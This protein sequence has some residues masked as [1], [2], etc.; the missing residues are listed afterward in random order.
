M[1]QIIFLNIMAFF[2]LILINLNEKRAFFIA[3]ALY[4]IIS[5]IFLNFIN[6]FHLIKIID[7]QILIM[8]N[9]QLLKNFF[10]HLFDILKFL[11]FNFFNKVY[12]LNRSE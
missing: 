9:I 4:L 5:I 6:I 10:Y 11:C 12:N 3:L 2:L 8:Q 1:I 7:A